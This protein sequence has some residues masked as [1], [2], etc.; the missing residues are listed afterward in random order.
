LK[1][2]AEKNNGRIDVKCEGGGLGRTIKTNRCEL[3]LK[4]EKK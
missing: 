2:E 3:F 4:E 1:E